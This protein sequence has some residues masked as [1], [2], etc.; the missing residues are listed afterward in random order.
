MMKRSHIFALL[1]IGIV[2]I[3]TATIFA[4]FFFASTATNESGKAKSS[5][6]NAKVQGV[7]EKAKNPPSSEVETSERPLDETVKVVSLATCWQY[8]PVELSIEGK[9]FK[10]YAVLT[11][12][13]DSGESITF[14]VRGWSHFSGYVAIAENDSRPNLLT[15]KTDE[16]IAVETQLNH[17]KSAVALNINLQGRE[18]LTF[19]KQGRYP[20]IV[21]CEPRLSR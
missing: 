2:G 7:K 3:T 10:S 5:A 1:F 17:G 21:I 12:G 20:E 18:T 11:Y 16:E 6:D 4:Y 15:I 14:D 8:H 9:L 19:K 13:C